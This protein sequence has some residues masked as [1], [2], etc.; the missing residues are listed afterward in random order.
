M[1]EAH[2]WVL[3]HF[4]EVEDGSI[5]DVEYILGESAAPKVSEREDET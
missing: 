5:V 2:V 4:D 3:E 1:P